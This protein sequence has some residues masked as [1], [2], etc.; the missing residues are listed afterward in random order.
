MLL[1]HDRPE[2]V[3]EKIRAEFAAF[4]FQTSLGAT[5]FTLSL[6]TA[7][8]KSPHVSASSFFEEAD[9]ALYQAKRNGKNCVV[10]HKN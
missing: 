6:G 1:P 10:A 2:V 7:V 9:N 8:Y 4:P 3:A 5:H